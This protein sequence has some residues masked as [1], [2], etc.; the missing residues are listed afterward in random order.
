MYADSRPSKDLTGTVQGSGEDLVNLRETER[1]L[2]SVLEEASSVLHGL[3]TGWQEERQDEISRLWSQCEAE[4]GFVLSRDVPGTPA[5]G[6]LRATAGYGAS[7]MFGSLSSSSGAYPTPCEVPTATAVE[8]HAEVE[9]DAVTEAARKDLEA[10]RELRRSIEMKLANKSD[11]E[12]S[13]LKALKQRAAGEAKIEGRR[14]SD[15][16]MDVERLRSKAAQM[17]TADAVATPAATAALEVS[18]QMAPENGALDDWME[19]LRS[20]CREAGEDIRTPHLASREQ[21]RAV[22]SPMRI[23]TATG[24]R[25]PNSVLSPPH[26]PSKKDMVQ[27][28]EQR[29]IEWAAGQHSA[30]DRVSSSPRLKSGQSSP[31]RSPKK[32]PLANRGGLL[33]APLI[34]GTSELS[35]AAREPASAAERQLDDI[36]AELDEIDRIHDDVC[37]LAH[38]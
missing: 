29:A 14:L 17:S 24:V 1:E 7:G 32:S 20:L 22:A 10:T 19:D 21:S 31:S 15:L 18:E 4:Y 26:S 36:L 3:Q 5:L 12:A 11:G 27:L 34:S 9:A 35:P 33:G 13:E 8:S 25:S 37:M 30:R 23:R 6:S 38:S 2:G 28:A 16:R